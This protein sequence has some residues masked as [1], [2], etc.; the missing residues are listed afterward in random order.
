M[1]KAA[2]ILFAD[3]ETSEGTGRMANALTT[4]K[5]FTDAGDESVLL[6]DG[7]GVRWIPPLADSDNEYHR[8]FE[9]V[10]GVIAGACVYCARAYAVRDE[11]E[12]AGIPFLDEFRG[13]PS[14]HRLVKEGY[15]IITF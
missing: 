2:I 5:E 4:A 10:R 1:N 9:D 11:I 14:I 13:H 3:A 7:A 6:F 15:E 12:A 8:L